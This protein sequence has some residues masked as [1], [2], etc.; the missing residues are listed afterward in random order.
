MAIAL[1]SRAPGAVRAAISALGDQQ[2]VLA[3]IDQ[4]VRLGALSSQASASLEHAATTALARKIPFVV[5]M[6]SS[7]AD[8]AE[9]M[10]ALHGWGIAARAIARCS[11]I[12]PVVMVVDGPAVSGPALLLGLA[13][14]VIAT[15]QSYAFVSGPTTPTSWAVR[16]RWPGIP[17]RP[18]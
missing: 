2:V 11:G 14:V 18:T 9:G 8:I 16:H 7:G 1:R 13:D 5:V 15:E 12:V 3:E 10:A 4:Q 6:A 17:A